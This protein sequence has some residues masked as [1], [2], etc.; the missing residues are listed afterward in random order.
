MK[1]KTLLEEFVRSMASLD[2]WCILTQTR[3]DGATNLPGES[4]QSGKNPDSPVSRDHAP[5]LDAQMES[6]SGG[7]LH[8]RAEIA[9]EGWSWC[10]VRFGA[11]SVDVVVY[12]RGRSRRC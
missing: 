1:L 10:F 11:T 7:G 9:F 3:V 8:R 6:I 4:I 12:R 5:D 2:P